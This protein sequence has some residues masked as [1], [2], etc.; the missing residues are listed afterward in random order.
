MVVISLVFLRFN[1]YCCVSSAREL[2]LDYLLVHFY[3]YNPLNSLLPISQVPDHHQQKTLDKA[4]G[5]NVFESLK[6]GRI[7][8]WAWRRGSS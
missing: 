7:E 1:I 5:P 3:N 8:G 6:L 4:K 2:T